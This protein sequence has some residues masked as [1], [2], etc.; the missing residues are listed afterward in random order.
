MKIKQVDGTLWWALFNVP[1]GTVRLTG[2]KLRSQLENNDEECLPALP[3]SD[4]ALTQGI[5]PSL[6]EAGCPAELET[7][8]RAENVLKWR[9]AE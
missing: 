3:C 8:E 5:K 4:P 2:L 6:C 9:V 1:R 7:M